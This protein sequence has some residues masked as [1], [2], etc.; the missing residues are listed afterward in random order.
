MCINMRHPLEILISPF[1]FSLALSLSCAAVASPNLSVK[2]GPTP[3][4][5]NISKK[6]RIKTYTRE[7]WLIAEKQIL[8]LKNPDLKKKGVVVGDF[9]FNNLS[10]QPDR[11]SGKNAAILNDFDDVGENFLVGDYI[12]F[13][14]F[15]E[16]EDKKIDLN[17]INKSYLNGLMGKTSSAPQ[18]IEELLNISDKARFKEEKKYHANKL[19]EAAAFEIEKLSRKQILRYTA[20]S[21][22][23]EVRQLSNP[24][25]I[26]KT[27]DSGSSIGTERYE[28]VSDQ[29][30]ESLEDDKNIIEFKELK[31]SATGNHEKQNIKEMHDEYKRFYTKHFPHSTALAFQKIKM[32]DDSY[33]LVRFK[34]NNLFKNI[35]FDKLNILAKQI[36]AEYFAEYLGRFHAESTN[37]QYVEAVSSQYGEIKIL[38]D[39]IFN[40]F[41]EEVK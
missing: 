30:V 31:C 40:E 34:Q 29:E 12:K 9:H 33:F 41:E 14:I 21:E 10:I 7:Y 28:F 22:T 38:K 11:V 37:P 8:Q 13:L 6:S 4:E 24:R 25:L 32:I 1:V 27:N 39:L 15:L 18:E 35:D 17:R 16:I 23:S 19:K 3:S 36:V 5:I 26:F 2:C 20:M